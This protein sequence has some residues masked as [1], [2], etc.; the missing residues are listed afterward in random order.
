MIST[1]WW[2]IPGMISDSATR[3][4]KV[5]A[6]RDGKPICGARVGPTQAFQWCAAGVQRDYLECKRCLKLTEGWR[7]DDMRFTPT[8]RGHWLRVRES[9]MGRRVTGICVRSEVD[10]KRTLRVTKLPKPTKIVTTYSDIVG[11]VRL[12]DEIEG[13]V[14]WNLDDLL[15]RRDWREVNCGQRCCSKEER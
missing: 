13:F 2:G 1:G 15:P 7:F 14:S 10:G 11:G 9:F 12:E 3:A 4:T 6:A 5:H 8:E